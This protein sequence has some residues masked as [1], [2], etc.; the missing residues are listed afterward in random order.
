MRVSL[1]S[2]LAA[3]IAVSGTAFVAS[4]ASVPIT[5][6][7][8]QSNSNTLQNQPSYPLT[9]TPYDF[10]GQVNSF[11]NITS[12]DSLTVTLE[13]ADGDTGPADY[14][15]NSLTLGLDGIDTGLKLN[16]FLDGS[17]LTL[18]LPTLSV[19]LQSQIITALAD[20][21]LVGSVIDATPGNAPANDFIGFPGAVDTELDLTVSGPNLQAGT[22]GNGG[23]N[24]VPLPAAVLVAP[25]GA[26]LAG[27][28]S[29]RFRNKK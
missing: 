8:A 2:V 14:D 23:G 5:S 9:G 21:K 22:G 7:V 26:G 6:I 19:G 1:K 10:T 20:G 16:G 18:T 13:V 11:A 24:N 29:R 17:I 25:L 27:I 3:A 15:F 4:A 28:Y 12:I